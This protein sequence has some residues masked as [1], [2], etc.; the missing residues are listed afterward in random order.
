MEIWDSEMSSF[1]GILNII[2]TCYIHSPKSAHDEHS[3]MRCC[4][5]W[6]EAH[7]CGITFVLLHGL[8]S[9]S[10]LVAAF[11][12]V[13]LS[14]LRHDLAEVPWII[15]HHAVKLASS[16]RGATRVFPVAF[17]VFGFWVRIHNYT[18]LGQKV[19]FLKWCI[20]DTRVDHCK[21]GFLA[22]ATL[23]TIHQKY[24]KYGTGK[25][26]VLYCKECDNESGYVLFEF[27]VHP[28]AIFLVTHRHCMR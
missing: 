3:T 20:R 18:V 4:R 15:L 1:R 17:F 28:R 24:T 27:G 25:T 11:S 21:P 14:Q 13:H 12:L 19:Y 22:C 6:S 8:D 26:M 2:D 9:N 5:H 16:P 7:G 10:T 23:D